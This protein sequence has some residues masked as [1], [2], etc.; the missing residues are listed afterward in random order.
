M[1]SAAGTLVAGLGPEPDHS[2]SSAVGDGG[3]DAGE[4]PVDGDA[5]LA[6][7]DGNP[8]AD[9][10][11]ELWARYMEELGSDADDVGGG[12]AE[13]IEAVASNSG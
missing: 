11:E 1:Q 6:L 9:G 3:D 2:R 10:K 7:A 4:Q 13:P 12:D 8:D 5:P